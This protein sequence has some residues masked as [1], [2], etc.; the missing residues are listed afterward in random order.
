[1][2]IQKAKLGDFVEILNLLNV[3][4][5]N[6]NEKGI[7]QWMEGFDEIEILRD[8]NLG[9]TYIARKDDR[10]IATFSLKT[11]QLDP[12]KQTMRSPYIYLY[13]LAIL[14]SEQR[15]GYG[16]RLLQ[17]AITLAKENDFELYLDCWSENNKLK[18][19]YSKAGFKFIDNIPEK[20]YS[21]SILK[22]HRDEKI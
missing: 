10:I 22:Y 14:P 11:K 5:M 9:R 6:L 3:V 1:M 18:K 12:I 19:I 2:K 15:R 21:I 20:D 4:K 13:K 17:Y 16:Q 7:M 8:I